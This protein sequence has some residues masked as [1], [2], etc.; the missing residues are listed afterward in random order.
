MKI[1]FFQSFQEWMLEID[2]LDFH[3]PIKA[4]FQLRH[5][6]HQLRKSDTSFLIDL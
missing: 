1:I 2:A 6:A 3:V 4:L 5:I